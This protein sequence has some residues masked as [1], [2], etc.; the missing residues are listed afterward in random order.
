MFIID[1]GDR[2]DSIYTNG[3]H[4]FQIYHAGKKLGYLNNY[5]K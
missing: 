3:L 2:I 1:A 5:N 4:H